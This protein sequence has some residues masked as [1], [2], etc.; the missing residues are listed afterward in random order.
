MN[1]VGG[2]ANYSDPGR[3]QVMP[4]LGNPRSL[5]DLLAFLQTRYVLACVFKHK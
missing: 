2:G 3:Q 5:T 1:L 4:D